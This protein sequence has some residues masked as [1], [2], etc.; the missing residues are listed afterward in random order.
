M[1]ELLAP[2]AVFA[3]YRIDGVAGRGGMGIVYRAT[4]MSLDRP[5]ALKLVAPELA[6]DER[7][8]RRFLNEPRLAASLDHPNVIPIYQAGEHDG[9]LY[10][11]MRYV[12]GSDLKRLLERE[13]ALPADRALALLGQVAD[14]LDAA[15]RR[16]LVHRDVKPGNVLVDEDD[17]AYLTDFGITQ[18]VGGDSTIT[19]EL[20]GTLDYL[21]PEQIRGERVSG[22]SDQYAL[23]CVLHQCLSGAA[24]FR[25]ATEAETMYAHLHDAPPPVP[26]RPELDGV[27]RR[28]LAKAPGDRYG[29]CKEM[30]AAA[31]DALAGADRRRLLAVLARRRR[32]LVLTG[33]A[34]LACVAAGIGVATLHGPEE[35]GSV[36]ITDGVVGLGGGSR[37]FTRFGAAPSNVAVGEGAVWVLSTENRTIARL[38]PKTGKIERRFEIGAVPSDIAVGEGA[39]WVGEGSSTAGSGGSNATHRIARVDL[40]SAK[41]TRTVRLPGSAGW[42]SNGYPG[43][44]VGGG[45]VW[46][47]APT[48]KIV[49]IDPRSGERVATLVADANTIASGDAGVWFVDSENNGVRRID[50]RTNRAGRLIK[51][52]A[53][54]IEGIAVGAGAVWVTGP[55]EGLV[56]RIDDPG[57][58]PVIRT[59]DVGRGVTYIA[60]GAGSVWTANYIDGAVTRID[61]RT[62]RV[63]GRYQVGAVQAL[64]ASTDTAW[65]SVAGGSRNGELPRSSCDGVVSGDQTPDV[66]I[67][68]D[69]PLQGPDSERPRAVAGAVRAVIEQH[70]FR[71]GRYSV[72]YQSCDES[73]SQSGANEMRRC[74]ANANAFARAKRVLAVIG[75][76][77]SFCAQVEIP[78]LNRAPGGPL[79][80]ISP[81]ATDQGL[82]RAGLG[83]PYGWRDEPGIYYPKGA[84]NFL[85]LAPTDN[86]GGTALARLASQLHVKRVY[87]LRDDSWMDVTLRDTFRAE[88]TRRGIDFAGVTRV[89]PK[90]R[91]AAVRRAAESGA[92]AVL[93]ATDQDPALARALRAGLDHRVKLLAG[94]LWTEPGGIPAARG[95]YIAT[96][97]APLPDRAQTPA[98]RRFLEQL[99]ADQAGVLEAAQAT[100]LALQAIARSDGKRASVVRELQR[101][102]VRDGLLPTAG[103][104]RYGDTTGA[105]MP[106]LRVTGTTT[107]GT[108][109]KDW[110]GTV[111]DRS[112]TVP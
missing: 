72:G 8:R 74:A 78:I 96:W 24:P 106:I 47:I 88:A 68:S 89:D 53:T 104:D 42:P 50:P 13:G 67:A 43:I 1:S 15:H 101:A 79:A 39:A 82:T 14:A 31:R 27:L 64:A 91:A 94:Y 49:R 52:G 37:S 20:V 58:R 54:S 66:L 75:P 38:D 35:A 99:G 83:P 85:R 109:V 107:P 41:V 77:T 21:A 55:Q 81:S 2:A 4:D 40:R 63:T 10:L 22:A 34:I 95:M 11:A 25:R 45:G 56:W 48:N 23:A 30:I 3:G 18:R 93:L 97:D 51:P 57:P 32:L 28:G 71:A 9:Q 80:L 7:F 17:H 36:P 90:D 46:A 59:I 44:A 60:F 103:F 6:L 92:D 26:G 65:V 105:R 61:P 84:R 19:S 102:Q 62:N 16:N 86:L 33:A 76:W 87:E 108:E 112:I 12:E 110:P 111:F 100:E 69:M 73:T 70:A 5:V 29:S 98:G